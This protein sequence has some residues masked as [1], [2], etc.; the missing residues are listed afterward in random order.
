VRAGA[1]LISRFELVDELGRGGMG[2]VYRARDRQRGGEVA[3]KALHEVKPAELLRFKREF[4]VMCNV[5]HPNLVRLGEL[6]EHDGGWFFTMELVEGVDFL[7]WVGAPTLVTADDSSAVTAAEPAA[8]ARRGDSPRTPG[9]SQAKPPAASQRPAPVFD[10]ARLRAALRG[11]AEGLAGLHR[12]RSGCCTSWS[13]TVQRCRGRSRSPPRSSTRTK[14]P[15]RSP[16]CV[17]RCRC[18]RRTT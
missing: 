7:D 15:M 9:D 12:R 6:V 11:V 3:L 1:T 16:S 10:E 17:P 2:I 18:S 4:R 5:R 13:P 8:A 14:P